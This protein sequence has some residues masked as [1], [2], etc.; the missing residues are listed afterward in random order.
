[1]LA[2]I[3]I[4]VIVNTF[5]LL[6]IQ[7]C[8]RR[9]SYINVFQWIWVCFFLWNAELDSSFVT[10]TEVTL[11]RP[12]IATGFSV[13][14][15]FCRLRPLLVAL[16]FSSEIFTPYR[17]FAPQ[18][19]FSD[20]MTSSKQSCC[21]I[22]DWGKKRSPFSAECFFMAILSPINGP[23]DVVRSLLN[24]SWDILVLVMP[25][26]FDTCLKKWFSNTHKALYLIHLR[27]PRDGNLHE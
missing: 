8:V 11:D 16:K 23:T 7:F 6:H 20:S 21:S 13:I 12:K 19:G 22:C 26:A 9:P 15:C 2:C 18:G 3:D 17:L 27:F 24:K 14:S 4:P 1:M 25:R 10:I 5:F